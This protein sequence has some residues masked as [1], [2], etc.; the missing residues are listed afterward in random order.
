MSLPLM[1]SPQFSHSD[2][3]YYKALLLGHS[4]GPALEFGDVISF[5]L[6][7][8]IIPVFFVFELYYGHSFT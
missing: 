6:Q 3:A 7:L 5:Y 4:R 1:S 8:F 2:S